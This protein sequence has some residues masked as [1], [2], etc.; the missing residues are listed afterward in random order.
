M[1]KLFG[2]KL[3]PSFSLWRLAQEA[4]LHWNCHR[5]WREKMNGTGKYGLKVL[6]QC[7]V[8]C[9]SNI[10]MRHQNAKDFTI[11]HHWLWYMGCGFHT[12]GRTN[13]NWIV[14]YRMRLFVPFRK[15]Q[16]LLIITG[17]ISNSSLLSV[18]MCSYSWM[19]DRVRHLIELVIKHKLWKYQVHIMQY[20]E[21][22]NQ[23]ERWVSNQSRQDSFIFSW[24]CK[25]F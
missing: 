21:N 13:L 12:Y 18:P 17:V 6:K 23:T 14:L 11:A 8:L 16:H 24:L 15:L 25:F 20:A 2:H 5:N 1:S 3:E 19:L 7:K 10:C 22:W 4:I 9:R